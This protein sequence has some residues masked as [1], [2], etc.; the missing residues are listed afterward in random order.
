[1]LI[2]SIGIACNNESEPDPVIVPE[3]YKFAFLK[4]FN[5]ELSEDIHLTIDG[6]SVTGIVPMEANIRNMVA[7]LHYE[8]NSAKVNGVQQDNSITPND[9][10]QIVPYTITSNDGLQ[11]NFTVDVT[12][13][14][15]LPIVH[16]NTNGNASINSKEDYVDGTVR[17]EGARDHASLEQATM[18]IKGRGNSTW[19]IHPKKPYQLKFPEK[20]SILDMPEDKKWIFLAEYSDKTLIRNKM[21]FELGYMSKIDW[22]PEGVFAE[23]FVNDAYQGTYHI[24]QKVEESDNRVPLG[25]TGYL[26]EIDQLDRLDPDDVY[27]YSTQFLINIKEPELTYGSAE[28]EYAKNLI[29]EFEDALFADTFKDPLIGYSKYIDVD[30]FIAWY[31]VSELTK[32]QDSRRF[33]SIFLNVMPGKKIKMGPLWDFDLAFGNVD[34]SECEYPTGFWVKYHNWYARLFEDPEFVQK[35]KERMS[36]F[37]DHQNDILNLMDS[38]ANY[39]SLAQQ[40]ND[41]RWDLFGNYVWPNPVVYDSHAQEV[42]HLKNWFSQRMNW[43]SSEI[44]AL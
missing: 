33:S 9:F 41:G 17:I 42:A 10:T 30:S 27:F 39:L 29:I 25:D 22:T 23:V 40:E 38:H 37:K 44:A 12:Y 15:G 2:A 7:T 16:I 31:M 3:L 13:F 18:K 11:F 28:Y 20:T 43:L 4:T 1:V 19:W 35:V 32:N 36:Y 34:Y 26:L 5:P 24:T 6:T 14:T 21:A 8:G